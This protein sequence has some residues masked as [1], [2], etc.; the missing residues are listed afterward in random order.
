[1]T[2][3]SFNFLPQAVVSNW[4][5]RAHTTFGRIGQNEPTCVRAP[6]NRF[7]LRLELLQPLR[8]TGFHPA[9]LGEPPMPR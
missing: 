3:S 6:V 2:F 4:K 8:I 5:S 1:M 7:F 9:V